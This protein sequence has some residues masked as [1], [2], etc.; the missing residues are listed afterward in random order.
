MKRAA[1]SLA[2]AIGSAALLAILARVSGASFVVG[3]VALVPWLIALART[4]SPL[5]ALGAGLAMSM[6]FV[7][8][9]FDWLPP[10]IES[11]AGG[12]SPWPWVLLVAL[13]PILEP[14]FLTFALVRHL[15]G[16]SPAPRAMVRAVL[17]GAATYVATELLSDKLLFDTL[18]QGLYPSRALRQGADL[19]G[20]HGL[21]LMLLLVN[22]A[23]AATLRRHP[24]PMS[25]AAFAPMAGALALIAAWFGYGWIRCAQFDAQAARESQGPVVGVVQANLTEYDKLRAERGAYDAVRL[26]LAE[27]D[28][29]SD[30]LRRHANPDVI[31]WPETV[32]PTT[33]GSPKS[34]AGAA[35]DLELLATASASGAAL[36]FGAYDTDTAGE[37]N[38][39]FFVSPT[40]TAHPPTVTTYRK[41]HLFPFTEHV[42]APFDTTWVHEQ[43]PWVGHWIRGPGPEVVPMKLRD[44]RTLSVLPLICYD[45][46]SSEFVAKAAN[47]GA[48]LIVTLSN[49]SWFPDARAPRLHGVSAAFRSIETRLPQVRATNSGISSVISPTGDW[50]ATAGWNERRVLSARVPRALPGF[51]PAVHLAPWLGPTLACAALVALLVLRTKGET[52][53]TPAPAQ[54]TRANKPTPRSGE[55]GARGRARSK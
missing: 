20:V 45:A 33:F 28:S 35:L 50:L 49:D 37:Y 41:N 48:E 27:H 4:R 30:E 11:Y 29:L 54:S 31:V 7:V 32:Y 25:R 40:P 16:R 47:R 46:L 15:V 53:R 34:E 18:G 19:V 5:E 8:A 1:I 55:R 2:G 9:V 36:V 26:I 24:K 21:T 42:P 12:R 23:V 22:E 13:A 10:T 52:R 17:L 14:Q 38:A 43:L 6:A 44:G 39:A 3:F 51:V